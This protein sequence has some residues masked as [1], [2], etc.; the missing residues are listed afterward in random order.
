M[1]NNDDRCIDFI[2]LVK[3]IFAQK[4]KTM[5]NVIFIQEFQQ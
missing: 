3:K 4:K 2:Q 1:N 5:Q